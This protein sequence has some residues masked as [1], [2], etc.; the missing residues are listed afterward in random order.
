[1]NEEPLIHVAVG[2]ILNDNSEILISLRPEE[3]HQG[4]LWEFPGGKVEQGEEIHVALQRELTE[5][6]GI[7]VLASRPFLR[8]Q[9]HYSDKSVLLD[10]WIVSEFSGEAQG[11]EGQVIE[12]RSIENLQARE[13]PKANERI[14]R[15]LS[16]PDRIAITPDAET[17]ENLKEIINHLLIQDLAIIY[18]RQ[19]TQSAITYL[20]WFNWADAKCREKQIKLLFCPQA[21]DLEYDAIHQFSGLHVTS[22]QLPTLTSRPISK[23]QLFSASCHTL[24]QLRLAE[25]LDVDFAFLSP[26]SANEKYSHEQLL[27]WNEF[28]RLVGQ[29][30]IPVYALGGLSLDDIVTCKSHQ[31][32]GLAGI[33]AFQSC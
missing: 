15:S 5:E 13:F 25:S 26:V 29:V 32:F 28:Q 1:M 23:K 20:Q 14:I 4:G 8:I 9:H 19:K 31:G 30:N 27:G 24:D 6:L 3:S 2:V 10:V 22:T 33:S 11:R 18:F 7:L 17:F 16:L 12:W 21:Q